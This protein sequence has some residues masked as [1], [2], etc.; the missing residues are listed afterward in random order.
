MKKVFLFA[1]FGSFFFIILLLAAVGG[2]GQTATAPVTAF[3]TEEEAYAYQYIGAELGVPWD[4]AL[5]VDGIS[6]YAKQ[7]QDLSDYNP[8]LTSLQFCILQ[9]EEFIAVEIPATPAPTATPEPSASPDSSA[10]PEPT[11]VPRPSGS[12]KPSLTPKPSFSPKPFEQSMV[13]SK[14]R[15]LGYKAPGESAITP[16]NPDATATPSLEPKPTT[17]PGTTV[18][19]AP[20]TTPEPTG[21][22]EP[23]APPVATPEP[24]I[25]WVSNKVTTYTGTS[26]I[27]AYIDV[28]D[29]DYRDATTVV[30]KINDTAAAKSTDKTKYEVTLLVN[31]D[32]ESV[33]LRLIGL[34]ESNTKSVLELYDSNYLAALYGYTSVFGDIVLPDIVQGNVSRADLA[35]VAISLINHPYLLGGKSSTVGAPTGP[36]DCSGYVDWVYMQC[37]GVTIGNGT[38]PEGVAVSGTAIQWYASEEIKASELRIGDLGFMKDP[39]LMKAGQINHV[40]IYLGSF[41][42]NAYWIHCGGK[43][44]GTEASPSGRVGISVVSG[45]NNFNPVDGSEFEPAMKG[46]RFR[47]YRRPRFTFT[48]D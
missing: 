30:N 13:R 1:S 11:G 42:G 3:A 12:P 24:E 46:C 38:V 22:P 37:F 17:A 36:L 9:E 45:M 26:E 25:I 19:P 7:K 40:G 15:V 31:P 16:A 34:S 20:T 18:T 29:I 28:Q 4:I 6:A 39:A 23:S 32:F 41:N 2:G 33:L 35:A 44:Y 48:D 47:F 43:A 5:L 21:T 8:M 27:L 14:R 10:T